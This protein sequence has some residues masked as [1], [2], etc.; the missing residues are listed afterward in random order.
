MRHIILRDV[1][2]DLQVLVVYL[3]ILTAIILRCLRPDNMDGVILPRSFLIQFIQRRR[4]PQFDCSK[5]EP[6]FSPLQ[7]LVNSIH[8]G[9]GMV[10]FHMIALS[11]YQRR[12]RYLGNLR[13]EGQRLD[14]A[15]TVFRSLL[16]SRMYVDEPVTKFA[17][18]DTSIPIASDVWF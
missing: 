8:L 7:Q 6:L 1:S 18:A 11:F 5:L 12:P 3:E 4:P 9:Q 10:L 15:P 14:K 17:A 16:I 2:I 13:V